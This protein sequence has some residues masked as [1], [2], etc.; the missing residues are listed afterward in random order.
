M[1]DYLE[2]KQ[3]TSTKTKTT[4]ESLISSLKV[5]DEDALQYG[6]K[7]MR[8]GVRRSRKQ[9]DRDA[10]RSSN[11]SD[12]KSKGSGGSGSN[13]SGSSSSKDWDSVLT[14]TDAASSSARYAKLTESAKKG[15][16]NSWSDADLKFYN[17][18][19]DAVTK[20][21]KM[22]STQG[23]DWLKSML[24]DLAKKNARKALDTVVDRQVSK[25]LEKYTKAP[26]PSV[27]ETVAQQVSKMRREAAV[28]YGINAAFD[29]GGT[30]IKG[31]PR[32]AKN[33]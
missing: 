3:L 11:E 14:S 28:E 12:S 18:R 1:K 15:Q 13:S 24:T 22:H 23:D 10:G 2:K 27:A 19:T 20:V 9:L 7:G 30:R 8:W 33:S 4:S 21:Q 16:T 25:Y 17:A 32:R 6:I 31:S 5:E 26:P 29:G